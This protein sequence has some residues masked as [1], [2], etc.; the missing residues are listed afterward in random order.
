MKRKSKKNKDIWN[1]NFNNSSATNRHGTINNKETKVDGI[2]CITHSIFSG[3]NLE[4]DN[5]QNDFTVLLAVWSR[6]CCL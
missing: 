1:W 5:F 3:S 4:M 6:K 2:F